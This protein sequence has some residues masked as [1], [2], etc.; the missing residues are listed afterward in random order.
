MLTKILL[1]GGVILAI[2]VSITFAVFGLIEAGKEKGVADVIIKDQSRI[3][4]ARESADKFDDNLSLCA[5]RGLRF[6]FA[7]GKCIKP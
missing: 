4:S 5:S 6:D 1:I 2:I 3:E 7:T